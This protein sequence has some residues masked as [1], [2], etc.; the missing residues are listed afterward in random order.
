[1]HQKNQKDDLN[2]TNDGKEFIDVQYA[3]VDKFYETMNYAAPPSS[4]FEP[5][6]VE[7]ILHEPMD[8]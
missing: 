7:I 5:I 3:V 2:K 4:I 6:V 1:M 8:D